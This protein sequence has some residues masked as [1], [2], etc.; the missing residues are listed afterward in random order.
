LASAFVGSVWNNKT[1][2]D[3]RVVVLKIWIDMDRNVGLNIV[4]KQ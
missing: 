2:P 3:E 1:G 4:Q